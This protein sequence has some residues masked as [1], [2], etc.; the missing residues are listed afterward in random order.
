MNEDY[1]DFLDEFLL[2]IEDG[3]DFTPE[4][5]KEVLSHLYPSVEIKVED[6][7][8]HN[9]IS[10][11][12]HQV[13]C[14]D[15]GEGEVTPVKRAYAVMSEWHSGALIRCL[16]HITWVS[17]IRNYRKLGNYGMFVWDD[18]ADEEVPGKIIY[19]TV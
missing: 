2:Q 7:A 3:F 11:P 19:G 13:W 9:K 8:D 17:P 1:T 6:H 14:C 18:M 15:S 4:S 16:I 5:V 12:P 10:L